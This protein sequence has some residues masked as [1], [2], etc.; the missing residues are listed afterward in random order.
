MD[1]RT[2]ALDSKD[3]EGGIEALSSATR[4]FRLKPFERSVYHALMVSVYVTAWGWIILLLLGLLKEYG[5][6]VEW[7]GQTG[8]LL[9]F[10]GAFLTTVALL[11]NIP[12]AAR[13][14]RE[15]GRLRELGL[16]S[17]SKSL[18][19]AHRRGRW[20]SRAVLWAPAIVLLIVSLVGT[21]DLISGGLEANGTNEIFGVLFCVVM[22]AV[23]AL[24]GYL[25]NQRERMEIA[26]GAEELKKALQN[27]QKRAGKSEK[28]SVPSE[29]LEK[30]AR[31]ETAQIAKERKDAVLQSV[32]AGPSGY[33]VAFDPAAAEQRRMLDAPDRVELEDVVAQ[34]SIEGPDK[35]KSDAGASAPAEGAT[36]VG[37][38]KSNRVKF[39][40]VVD[41]A[42][43]GIRII[44]VRHQDHSNSSLEGASHA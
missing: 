5:F 44:A 33:G 3:L 30:A 41:R 24:S 12:L 9:V 38:T 21:L 19:K 14:Y 1:N 39:E 37:E 40:Y 2:I 6:N 35:L 29:L 17:L 22:V 34:L 36:R 25:R 28:V 11:L 42:S 10:L 16:A 43:H 7:A 18:W 15:R 32:S 4:A 13:L 27:L 8:G 31:I 20:A 23:L 26:A